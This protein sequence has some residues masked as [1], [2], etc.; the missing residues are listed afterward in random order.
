[1]SEFTEGSVTRRTRVNEVLNFDPCPSNGWIKSTLKS[2]RQRKG[3][4]VSGH[5][6]DISEIR[7]RSV[8]RPSHILLLRAQFCIFT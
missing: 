6:R 5:F 8:H 4:E 3:K 1:M 7:L 2:C